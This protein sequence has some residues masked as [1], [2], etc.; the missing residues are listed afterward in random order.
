M[1]KTPQA[2][3]RVAELLQRY[4]ETVAYFRAAGW[5]D[6]KIIAALRRKAEREQEQDKARLAEL[7]AR[8]RT[9]DADGREVK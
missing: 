7:V 3:D 2:T 9:F 8:V 1:T 4:A 5:S 6:A